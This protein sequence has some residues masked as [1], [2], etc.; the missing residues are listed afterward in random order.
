MYI[1]YMYVENMYKQDTIMPRKHRVT[2]ETIGLH[3]YVYI[4]C[5][6]AHYTMYVCNEH[7]HKTASS[8]Q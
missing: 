8:T 2:L 3:M 5:E 1:M 6:C 7:Y 4:M